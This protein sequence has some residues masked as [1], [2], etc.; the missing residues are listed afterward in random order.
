MSEAG[1]APVDP[2]P[3]APAPAPAPA[4]ALLDTSWP[5]G[6]VALASLIEFAAAA[7]AENNGSPCD[8]PLNVTRSKC[9]WA[10]AVGVIA[11]VLAL[12]IMFCVIFSNARPCCFPSA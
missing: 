8:A 6:L 4:H 2:A 3:P 9:N 10:I 11:F 1:A 7:D 12:A 5:W